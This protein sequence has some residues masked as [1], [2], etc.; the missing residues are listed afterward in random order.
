MVCHL[1][2]IFAIA[3]ILLH[4]VYLELHL[5][6]NSYHG[7]VDDIGEDK[8]YVGFHGF[9]WAVMALLHHGGGGA[10]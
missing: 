3:Y 9:I 1:I 10:I 8:K 7:V 4:Y 6:Q 2:G 5:G